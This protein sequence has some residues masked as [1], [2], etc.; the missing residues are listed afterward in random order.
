MKPSVTVSIVTYN[1]PY[2]F[3]TLDS[4]IDNVRPNY[5]IDIIVHDNGSEAEYIEKLEAYEN[6]DVRILK[7]PNEG[8]GHGHNNVLNQISTDFFII[9]NPD[10]LI[11]K[12]SFEKMYSFLNSQDFKI[13]MLTPKI[14]GPDG[15]T[16]YLIRE[17]L[18]VFDY[19]LR[20]IPFKFIKRI[21]DKRLSK[22]ECRNLK[23]NIQSINY[24]SGAFMFLRTKVIRDIKGFDERFFM[25]FEDNDLCDRI[26]ENG[27]KIYY[28]PSAIVTHYYGME[29]H[30]S[31]K[32]FK[33]FIKSMFQY[34]N[35]WGWRFF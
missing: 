28:I 5:D 20:F 34:F 10:I 32:G 25:Y 24:G 14:V 7:G 21:F 23:D 6:K 11:T 17:K 16:Q 26:R 29:S 9:C 12:E 4:W 35:K 2:I 1:S 22:Y 8:F 13:G 30:R 18:D 3:K 19:M 27:N 33:V 15:K 31:L